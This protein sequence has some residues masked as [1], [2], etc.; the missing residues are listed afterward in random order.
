[1]LQRLNDRRKHHLV[2]EATEHE[3]KPETEAG[4]V[5]AVLLHDT[6]VERHVDEVFLCATEAA[7]QAILPLLGGEITKRLQSSFDVRN[8]DNGK[9]KLRHIASRK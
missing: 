7:H 3:V 6:H 2:S 1:M 9:F 4:Q 8:G 5:L